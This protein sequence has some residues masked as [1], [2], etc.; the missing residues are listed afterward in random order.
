M[1]DCDKLIIVAYVHIE[2]VDDAY[3]VLD[4]TKTRLMKQFDDSVKVFVIPTKESET[5][6]EALNPKFVS[7]EDAKAVLDRL[8][9]ALD[10]LESEN[11]GEE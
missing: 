3:A 2:D 5:Y 4:V 7:D 10:N 9:K 8:N 11:N 1:K 6:L